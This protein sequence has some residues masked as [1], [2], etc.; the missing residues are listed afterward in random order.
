MSASN[1]IPNH[2]F[3]EVVYK[4]S[5]SFYHAKKRVP[6]WRVNQ[7]MENRYS[8]NKHFSWRIYRKIDHWVVQ[9]CHSYCVK[10][11]GDYGCNESESDSDSDSDS[12]EE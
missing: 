5:S 1:S 11:C 9:L 6:K 4:C 8:D 12:D 7:E 3:S 2:I 10:P